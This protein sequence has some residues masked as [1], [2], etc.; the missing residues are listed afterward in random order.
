MHPHTRQ[1]P[2]VRFANTSRNHLFVVLGIS[3]DICCF[4]YLL[5][6]WHISLFLK[7]GAKAILIFIAPLLK[8]AFFAHIRHE[9]PIQGAS[10]QI[11][12]AVDD[13]CVFYLHNF[14]LIVIKRFY[15]RLLCGLE[16]Y[17]NVL[18][19]AGERVDG[20]LVAHN[21][22]RDIIPVHVLFLTV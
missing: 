7:G 8:V 18:R 6:V 11:K 1:T 12:A 10:Y 9:R 4:V 5:E 19:V 22:P 2:D 13:Y 17:L 15:Y 3:N 20:H 21:D 16:N 14:T